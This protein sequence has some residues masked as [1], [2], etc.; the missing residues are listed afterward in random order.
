MTIAPVVL[1]ISVPVSLGPAGSNT[2]ACRRRA[3]G[4]NY[5]KT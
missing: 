3:R 4:Y 2:S 1:T 5:A